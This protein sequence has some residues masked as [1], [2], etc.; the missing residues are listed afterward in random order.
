[1]L[2]T[3]LHRLLKLLDAR[4]RAALA[5]VGITGRRAALLRAIKEQGTSTQTHL[6]NETG[7]DRS[8]IAE[9]IS[10]MVADG[11][12]KRVRNAADAR[13]YNVTLT[14]EGLAMMRQATKAMEKAER[15]AIKDLPALA[16]VDAAAD[17]CLDLPM[18]QA[19]E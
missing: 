19:A 14:S 3:K 15:E 11:L 1:M 12:I 9:M 4:N 2:V 7:I 6:T 16:G 18:L 8:T 13:A 17:V 5:E 10:R